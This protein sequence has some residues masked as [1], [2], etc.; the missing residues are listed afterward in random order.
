MD[1]ARYLEDGKLTI[2]RRNGTYYA[3]LRLSPGKYVTRS[4]KTTVEEIAVQAGRRLLFQL[5]H[6]AEQGLPPKSKSFSAVIDDY[7]RFRER[8]HAHGKT[9]AGMLRQIRRVSKFWREYAGQLAVEDIDDKVMREFIPWRRDY[10]ASF[11]ALPK[12][13]KRHPSD[14]TLQWDMMLGKAIVKWA[15]E[16]RG[17]KPPITVSFTPKKKRVRPAF[18]L[19]E[20]R[21][22]WRT[23]CRRIKDSRDDRTRK[24]RELLRIYVL[25]LANSGFR[26]GEANNVG[27]RDVHP[28]KDD[29][30]RS[31]YRFVVRGK[32]GERDVIIRSA[33]NKRVDK[34]LTKRRLE[35]PNG[36]LFVMPD[37]SEIIT[38]IDQFNA[39]LRD[40]G[41]LKSSFGE[42]Y[43]IYSLRHFYAVQTLRNGVG[44]FEVARNMGTSVEVIQ[45]Y[46]GKQAT[47]AVF[48]TRLGD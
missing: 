3:R 10:Y 32:T 9:S 34:Y 13:A 27:V 47:A 1:G 7:I 23:L 33:A 41:T 40:A 42:K 46:Y 28:F 43:T 2:F 16:L 45:E 44:V 35:D 19:W 18:E 29:K 31:N 5:E 11:D 48:A 22:L 4:L 25:I 15:A 8:D 21:Q 36:L 14:K 6:R 24:S 39:A 37:G 38:L 30:G 20:F 26:P 12:N 17:N